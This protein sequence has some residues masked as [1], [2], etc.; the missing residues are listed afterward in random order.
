MIIGSLATFPGRS[1]LLKAVVTPIV[2]QVDR[3]H[4]VLN[5]YEEIPGWF[6]DFAN[7]RPIIPERDTKDTGK[8]LVRPDP[9]DWLVTFDDDIYYPPD[10]VTAGIRAL[11]AVGAENSIGGYHG[12]NYR[13]PRYLPRSRMLR[14][15]IGANVN[16]IVRSRRDYWYIKGLDEPTIVEEL[17]TGTTIMKGHLV[18][19]FEFVRDAQKFIDVRLARWAYERGIR[20]VCLPRSEKWLQEAETTAETS[21]FLSYTVKAPENVAREIETYAF[22]IPRAGLSARG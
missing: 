10:Y 1:H 5:E 13:R 3:L 8:F 18:P 12:S 2:P 16:Y 17:G 9:E 20:L 4:V 11:E 7:V 19:P 15:L 6:S 22:K 21:I 14:R